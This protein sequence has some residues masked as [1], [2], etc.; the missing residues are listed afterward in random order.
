MRKVLGLL[1]IGLV[2]IVS[3]QY[4]LAQKANTIAGVQVKFVADAAT[5]VATCA[6]YY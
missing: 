1:L 2:G 4:T 3:A 6:A 5:D